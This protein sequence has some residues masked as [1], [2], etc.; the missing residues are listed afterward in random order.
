M[1]SEA[2]KKWCVIIP[3]F[4]N[5]RTLKKVIDK[6]LAITP[7][8]FVVNDGSTD[9]TEKILSSYTQIEVITY[10]ENQGKGYALRKGFKRAI[11][12]GYDYA[13]TID[14]DGQHYPSDILTFLPHMDKSREVLV[15]GARTLPE[16]RLTKGSG[17][18]NRFSNFWF[19]FITGIRL[20]D[21]QSGYRLYS[22]GWMR[23]KRFF[24][25]KYEFELEV[26]VRA[27]WKGARVSSIPIRVYYPSPAERVSHYR[28]FRDFMRISLLNT[29]LV[30]IAL[31][32]VKPFTFIR[33]L[34]KQ[35]I[36]EFLKRQ[37][38]HNPDSSLKI[39]LSVMFGV[40][41]G[42]VP[43]WGYQLI[44]ALALA[45]VFRLNK[46]I[47]AVA[48]NISIPPMIPLILYMSYVTGGWILAMENHISLNDQITFD[49]VKNNLFQYVVGSIAFGILLSCCIGIITY[50]LLM[51]IRRKPEL[52][53]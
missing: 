41:M 15:V 5:E 8:V 39:T 38:F 24:T 6:V 43:I 2:E 23:Y 35:S 36:K 40:F 22:L 48:A 49:Y 34:N 9:D 42:I 52:A 1:E 13:I 53:S 33:Y 20:P 47:V 18:A 26:L 4:N 51:M 12:L 21:T 31:L 14:S 45:Y 27:A 32:Y 28:P 3:T 17:F 44:T 46:F 29:V 11:D 16:E 30:M 37:I 7:H 50:L 25:R 19:R 10:V